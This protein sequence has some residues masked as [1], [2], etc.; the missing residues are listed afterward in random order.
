MVFGGNWLIAPSIPTSKKQSWKR[1]SAETAALV[2]CDLHFDYLKSQGFDKLI[3]NQFTFHGAVGKVESFA[4]VRTEYFLM[5]C[6]YLAQSDE[7]KEGLI[8]LIFNLETGARIEDME[9]NI[10]LSVNEFQT[11]EKPVIC[12]Q[13]AASSFPD[14]QPRQQI[15]GSHGV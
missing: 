7:Q 9:Q 11:K 2:E 6:K 1:F 13:K 14:L 4:E 5:T 15:Y 12:R 8:R 10:R 3:R